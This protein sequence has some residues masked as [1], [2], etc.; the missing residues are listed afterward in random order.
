[1]NLSK[2][3]WT[4]IAVIVAV[5]VIIVIVFVRNSIPSSYTNSGNTVNTITDNSSTKTNNIDFTNEIGIVQ[6]S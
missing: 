1:M 5:V 2:V 4:I 3:N 6:P